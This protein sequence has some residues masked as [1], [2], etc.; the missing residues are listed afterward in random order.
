MSIH[1]G[2]APDSWGVWRPLDS[3]QTPWQRFLDEVAASGYAAIELGPFGY[4]PTEPQRVE[5]ELARRSLQLA[6]GTISGD[7]SA[8]DGWAAMRAT[9][10]SICDVLEHL[11]AHFLVVLD[12]GH[13]EPTEL[14][15]PGW[16]HLRDTVHHL[17]EYTATRGIAAVFHPHADSTIQFEP[18]IERF[19][20]LTD[21]ALVNL[22]LDVGHHAYAGGDAVSF[23]RDH[24]ARTPYL[25]LKDVDPVL[26]QRASVEGWSMGR[27]V[28]EGAF[29]DLGQGCVDFAAL[30]RVAE[31]VGYDSW[32]I[33][34]QDMY[35]APFDK[36]L[37]IARRNRQFLRDA[38]IG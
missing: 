13:A 22:C 17:G 35:P 27:A 16:G 31:Q 14:D 7:L 3:L 18:Q 32:G 5:E 21:A 4:L 10:A 38:R 34:E 2:T 37:P 6:G 12:A 9:T 26:S 29:V 20:A 19:L 33:V 24:H 23:F 11:G 25:H 30:Q 1:V 15:E 8:P 28:T 36:P